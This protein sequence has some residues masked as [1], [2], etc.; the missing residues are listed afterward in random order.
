MPDRRSFGTA[1]NQW[2]P[3]KAAGKLSLKRLSDSGQASESEHVTNLRRA[4]RLRS[5]GAT[6]R[7]HDWQRSQTQLQSERPE[8]RADELKTA[9][10]FEF[11]A[12]NEG[13]RT[14]PATTRR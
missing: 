8:S 6:V 4:R 7:E 9:D 12:G 2:P 13:P 5:D 14:T 3:V 1:G 11:G 10:A